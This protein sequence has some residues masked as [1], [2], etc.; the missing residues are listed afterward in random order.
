MLKLILIRK[1]GGG[2][3]F[4]YFAAVSINTVFLFVLKIEVT[5]CTNLI[6]FFAVNLFFSCRQEDSIEWNLCL[7]K[8][9][10]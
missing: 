6:K 10:I 3:H 8:L 5:I 9:I 2:T 4:R 7:N 1:E